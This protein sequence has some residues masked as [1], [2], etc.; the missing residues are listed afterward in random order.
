MGAPGLSDLEWLQS[1]L[2]LRF[3]GMGIKDPTVIL[4]AARVAATLTFVERAEGLGRPPAACRRPPDFLTRTANLQATLGDQFGPLEQW[5]A[6]TVSKAS[7]TQD[8]LSQRWWTQKIH[9][10]RVK[11]LERGLPLRDRARYDLQRMAGTTSW[12]TVTPSEGLGL[13][14]V[15]R[16]Y[17]LLLK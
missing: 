14:L 13:K 6:G 10:A 4:P 5:A 1:T 3:A 8:H 12:M 11:R 17:R 7:V 15:G 16:D 9:Q 2:S